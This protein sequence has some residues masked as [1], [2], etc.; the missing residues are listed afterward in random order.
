MSG[1][2]RR[3]LLYAHQNN[4]LPLSLAEIPAMPG[5]DNSIK[6]AW[7]WPLRYQI[8]DNGTITLISLGRDGMPGGVGEDADVV[9]SF[10]THDVHGGW[11]DPLV[12]WI[13][14]N[15]VKWPR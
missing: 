8:N 3:I 13:E 12:G 9:L 7:G 15:F 6:D 2:K 11:S 14:E 5:Y 1:V 10:P 4:R